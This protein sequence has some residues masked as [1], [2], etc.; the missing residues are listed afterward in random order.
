MLN[1]SQSKKKSFFSIFSGVKK[2]SSRH[3]L[4]LVNVEKPL[5]EKFFPWGVDFSVTAVKMVRLGTINKELQLLDVIIEELPQE[6]WNSPLQRKSTVNDIFKRLVKQ[7]RIKGEIVTAVPSA[8]VEMKPMEL[9]P[10]PEKEIYP[11][12]KW[13]LKQSST[14]PVEELV[15]DYYIVGGHTVSSDKI[16]VIVV[17][18]LKKDVIEQINM[19]KSA[20]LIPLSVE[21]DCFAVQALI[22]QNNQI[23]KEEIIVL[24]EFGCHS[25]TISIVKDNQVYFKRNLEIT[26]NSLTQGIVQKCNVSYEQAEG[27]KR[28]L[29]LIGM[30]WPT[31]ALQGPELERAMRVNEI[32]WQHVEDLIQEITYTFKYFTHQFTSGKVKNYDRIVLSGGVANLKNLSSFLMSYLGVPVEVVDPLKGIVLNQDI[33]LKYGNFKELAPRLSVAVGLA[34]QEKEL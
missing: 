11:A 34:L 14:I 25:C 6:L 9:P 29:G 5:V 12:V 2:I 31:E 24:L 1:Y 32:L 18:C 15:F 30:E 17:S 26:G 21:V 19:I 10:M 28:N 3:T 33:I 7:Y 8:I 13:E 27:L 20:D 16:E 22:S 4:R 23:K